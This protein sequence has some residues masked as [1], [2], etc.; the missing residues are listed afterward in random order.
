MRSRYG[1]GVTARVVRTSGN[2]FLRARHP[3]DH[4][5]YQGTNHA[6][7]HPSNSTIASRRESCQQI[8]ASAN[9]NV[10]CSVQLVL[11][12]LFFGRKQAGDVIREG[13]VVI[14]FVDTVRYS[15]P[16]NRQ[17]RSVRKHFFLCVP[18]ISLQ[19]TQ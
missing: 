19:C 4:F 9:N 1:P 8:R 10:V 15:Q 5:M 13:T 12:C 7:H 17:S 3:G 6:Y 16:G 2:C 14:K 11:L 18:K